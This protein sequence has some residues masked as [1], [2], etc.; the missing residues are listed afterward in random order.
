MIFGDFGVLLPSYS[1]LRNHQKSKEAAPPVIGQV[2]EP[3]GHWRRKRSETQR[4]IALATAGRF[5]R[6]KNTAAVFGLAAGRPGRRPPWGAACR[7]P[8]HSRVAAVFGL[9]AGRPGHSPQWPRPKYFDLFHLHCVA[10][11]PSLHLR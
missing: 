5:G 2:R 11:V 1:A 7:S 6:G 8:E 3:R 9:A 4:A 10:V